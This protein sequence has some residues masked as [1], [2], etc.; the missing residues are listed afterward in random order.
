M[1]TCGDDP[2]PGHP[3]SFHFNLHTS[4]SLEI[5]GR[6]RTERSYSVDQRDRMVFLSCGMSETRL[7]NKPLA[8]VVDMP[9]LGWC[10][11]SYAC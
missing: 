5:L 1:T 9:I 7:P 6:H 3:N 2:D 11:Y 4:R 10:P 8:C